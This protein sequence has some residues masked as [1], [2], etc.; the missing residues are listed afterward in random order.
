VPEPKVWT[1]FYEHKHG[2]DISVY[3]TKRGAELSAMGVVLD[4]LDDFTGGDEKAAQEVKTL[5]AQKD[6]AG[7]KARLAKCPSREYIEI[8]ERVVF[9]DDECEKYVD[10]LVREM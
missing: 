9:Q 2:A 5:I 7:V 4:F 1:L 3:A 6:W 10:L 8:D